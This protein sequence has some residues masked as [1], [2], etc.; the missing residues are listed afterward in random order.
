MV[1]RRSLRKKLAYT[2]LTGALITVGLFSLT[3]YLILDEYFD[4]Q[5]Q[6][7]QQFVEEQAIQAVRVNLGIF[8]DKLQRP[9][10]GSV[11]LNSIT[12][13]GVLGD[14]LSELQ[15]S[16]AERQATAKIL[17]GI[18]ND[19]KL[20][21]IT[22]VGLDGKVVLRANDP[23]AFGDETLTRDYQNDDGP[24]SSI[25]NLVTATLAG[26]TITAFE[27]FAPEILAYEKVVDDGKVSTLKAEAAIPLRGR[28]AEAGAIETRGLMVT[29]SQPVVTSQGKIVGAIIAG[30]LLNQ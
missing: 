30:K 2:F 16:N 6:V 3:I 21:M 22:V 14:R 8:K 28:D 27:V 4:H 20:S 1:S 26:K 13:S 9:A 19:A 17:Q 5:K 11:A 29:L 10:A 25:R 24:V 7:R 12:R 18:Q 15:H 23:S